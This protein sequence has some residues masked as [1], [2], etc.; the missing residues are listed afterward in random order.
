MYCRLIYTRIT[1]ASL[2]SFQSRRPILIIVRTITGALIKKSFPVFLLI[3]FAQAAR[4]WAFDGQTI[5]IK[6]PWRD[7]FAGQTAVYHIISNSPNVTTNLIWR[8]SYN[9]R[10]LSQGTIDID[11]DSSKGAPAEL[12]LPVP[13]VKEGVIVPADLT[14]MAGAGPVPLLKE[15]FYIFPAAPFTFQEKW[16]ADLKIGLYDP[17]KTTQNIFESMGVPFH[18]FSNIDA[19]SS[20][21][22]KLFIVGQDM[23]LGQ[24]SGFWDGLCTL[25]QRQVPILVLAPKKGRLTFTDETQRLV[26]SREGIIHELDKSLDTA[27][28]PEGR[29]SISGIK[30][31]SQE[32]NTY[33]QVEPGPENWPW[34]EITFNN[35]GRIIICGFDFA[36]TADH[37]PAPR[38]FLAR[39]I[40]YL[41]NPHFKEN[42]K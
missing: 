14:L 18:P 33:G 37:S 35:G 5:L 1:I 6:E 10:T 9:N 31:S 7:L 21:E 28:A 34:V 16:L 4:V 19:L 11:K 42:V 27:W 38:Y 41:I 12:A 30:V 26:L 15:K 32:N 3:F 17:Q 2:S 23:D 8:L 13:M 29:T 40:D 36:G 20:F 39:L 22:G 25:A 24:D